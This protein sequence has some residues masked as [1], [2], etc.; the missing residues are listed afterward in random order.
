MNPTHTIPTGHLGILLSVLLILAGCSSADSGGTE[1]QPEAAPTGP[2]IS[3]FGHVHGLGIN[4]ADD[5]AYIAT[6]LGVYRID[7]GTTTPIADRYQD[8]MA[9]TII[10]PNQFLASGHPDPREDLPPHLG[11]IESTDAATSWRS[12]SLLGEADFHA[13]EAAGDLVYGYNSLTGT[14]MTTTDRTTWQPAAEIEIVDLGVE[15]SEPTTV[16]ATTPEAQLLRSDD[17]GHTFETLSTAPELVLIDW[18]STGEL[19]GL[20]PDGAVHVSTDSAATWESATQVP[21]PP[22]AIDI[23]ARRWHVATTSGLYVSTDSGDSWQSV[24][25]GT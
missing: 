9:F 21:G 3:Q 16:L 8:T 11:L 1:T 19:V 17:G 15:T 12:L 23:T 4:P 18:A 2:A 25:V 6:H 13:L 20:G 22:Q 10:G 5:A 14:L 24:P 7:D